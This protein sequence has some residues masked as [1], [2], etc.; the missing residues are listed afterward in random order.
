MDQDTDKEV[1]ILKSFIGSEIP[2][3]KIINVSDILV[4]SVDN[5]GFARNNIAGALALG[6]IIGIAKFDGQNNITLGYHPL[7]PVAVIANAKQGYSRVVL[8]KTHSAL[9]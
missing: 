6:K 9:P 4:L 5:Q 3:I 2:P 7:L 1:Y 8:C